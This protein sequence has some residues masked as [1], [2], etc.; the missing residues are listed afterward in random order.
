MVR[1]KMFSVTLSKDAQKIFAFPVK[2]DSY[3][4]P[5]SPD[6]LIT[7]RVTM[8]RAIEKAMEAYALHCTVIGEA[9][10]EITSVT[11][12]YLGVVEK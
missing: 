2:V 12:S 10:Q 4:K 8:F 7:S 1:E 3:T 5:S 6:D 9:M 11:A